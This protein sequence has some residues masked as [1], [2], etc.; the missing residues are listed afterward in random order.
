MAEKI[1]LA[2][3]VLMWYNDFAF[4]V[5]NHIGTK[6]T[7]YLRWLVELELIQLEQQKTQLPFITSAKKLKLIL[8]R[9]IKGT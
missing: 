4:H 8:Y 3:E 6:E 2:K 5:G 7:V 9:V 1:M